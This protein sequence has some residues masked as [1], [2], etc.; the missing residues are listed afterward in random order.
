[1]KDRF[2]HLFFSIFQ[3]ATIETDSRG[4]NIIANTIYP[5][6]SIACHSAGIWPCDVRKIHNAYRHSSCDTG[7]S[8]IHFVTGK[9]NATDFH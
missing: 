5:A 4:N 3:T 6:E 7:V 2:K 8:T 9:C 1:M